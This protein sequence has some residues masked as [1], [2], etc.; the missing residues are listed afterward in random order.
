[1]ARVGINEVILVAVA[2]L[3]MTPLFVLYRPSEE[4]AHQVTF[5]EV[6]LPRS[7]AIRRNCSNMAPDTFGSAEAQRKR[8]ADVQRW[9]S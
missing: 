1:V 8:F 3:A 6:S 4:T 9:E 5:S 2:S 7:F